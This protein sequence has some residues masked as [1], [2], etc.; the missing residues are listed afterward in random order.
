MRHDCEDKKYGSLSPEFHNSMINIEMSY[1]LQESSLAAGQ[2]ICEM[3]MTMNVGER[4]RDTTHP[5]P[6]RACKT[7]MSPSFTVKL[8][9]S[10]IGSPSGQRHERFFTASSGAIS[11]RVRVVMSKQKSDSNFSTRF[12]SHATVRITVYGGPDFPFFCSCPCS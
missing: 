4:V 8:T 3:M 2:K 7:R 11:L 12:L 10:N 1:T 5:E 9:F 6:L